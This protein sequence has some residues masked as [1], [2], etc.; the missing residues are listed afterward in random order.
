[1]KTTALP[2]LVLR[3]IAAL[4][5]SRA[6]DLL[7]DLAIRMTARERH[8]RPSAERVYLAGPMSGLPELNYP[9]FHAEAAR[10]RALGLHVENP[11]DNPKP[12]CGSWEGYMCLALAQLATCGR[13]H[14]LPGWSRSP[15]ALV[16]RDTAFALGLDMTH[17]DGVSRKSV[18]RDDFMQKA[19]A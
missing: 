9:T 19:A 12:P 17:A 7:A 2:P 11:A 5:E 13:I 6:P 1:M 15:G 10:L 4:L 16:E 8:E 14:L 18:K 3:T